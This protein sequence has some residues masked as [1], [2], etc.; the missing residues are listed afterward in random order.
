V[1]IKE[2]YLC[3]RREARRG[4]QGEGTG[5]VSLGGMSWLV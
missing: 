3:G 4:D 2:G 1:G 5:L